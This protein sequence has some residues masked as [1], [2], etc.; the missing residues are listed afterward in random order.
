MRAASGPRLYSA[1]RNA[2]AM[3]APNSAKKMKNFVL[4][5]SHGARMKIEGTMNHSHIG[6]NQVP[7][8]VGNQRLSTCTAMIK[9]ISTDVFLI[10]NHTKS[11]SAQT[12]PSGAQS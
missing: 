2:P 10:Q 12:T 5:H 1:A 3:M 7:T 6:A 8:R 4:S 11:G 9:G